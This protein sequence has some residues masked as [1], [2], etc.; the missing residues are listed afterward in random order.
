M[1]GAEGPLEPEEALVDCRPLKTEIG[2]KTVLLF[3]MHTKTCQN[4]TKPEIH[5]VPGL[6]SIQEKWGWLRKA[7]ITGDH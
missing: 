2:I 4:Q 7:G 1:Q 3:S 5:F 6:L